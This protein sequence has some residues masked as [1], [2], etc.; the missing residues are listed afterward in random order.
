[1]ASTNA[2]IVFRRIR[3][4]K[5]VVGG[6]VLF[7]TVIFSFFKKR[8]SGKNNTEVPSKKQ[9]MNVFLKANEYGWPAEYLQRMVQFL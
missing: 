6:E 2:K 7:I 4:M 1:M 3:L 8:A 5:S 9:I